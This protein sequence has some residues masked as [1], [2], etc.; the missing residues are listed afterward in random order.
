MAKSQPVSML[1]TYRP[2]PGKAAEL[3]PLVEKHGRVLRD[4]GLITAQPVRV[5]RARD[6]RGHGADEPYFVEMFEW[7]DADAST[8]A[9]QTPEVMA[10]WEPMGPLLADLGLTSIE[11]LTGD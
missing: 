6:K 7:R 8:I 4:T 10:I 5:F 1:V 2:K 9:H 11:S 3:Q